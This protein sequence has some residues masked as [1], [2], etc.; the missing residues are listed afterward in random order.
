MEEEWVSGWTVAYYHCFRL[1]EIYLDEIKTLIY[2]VMMR[3]T[4]MGKGQEGMCYEEQLRTKRLS[5]LE[6]KRPEGQPYWC[7]QLP[8]E[9]KWKGRC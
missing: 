5:N 4:K 3:A 1:E 2:C 9:G 7:L 8:E 6:K